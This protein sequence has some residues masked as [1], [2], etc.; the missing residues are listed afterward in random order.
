MMKKRKI[1]IDK[2]AL[3]TKVKS[4]Q[5]KPWPYLIVFL[6]IVYCFVAILIPVTQAYFENIDEIIVLAESNDGLNHIF[7]FGLLMLGYMIIDGIVCAY[8]MLGNIYRTEH[9][10]KKTEE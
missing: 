10:E 9:T 1:N 3:K 6:C 7:G 8:Y 4:W 5:N 2:E